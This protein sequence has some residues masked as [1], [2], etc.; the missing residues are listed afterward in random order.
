[1]TPQILKDKK[2]RL[3]S[4]V[5]RPWWP[6]AVPFPSRPVPALFRLHPMMKSTPGAHPSSIMVVITLARPY[7]GLGTELSASSNI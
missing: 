2:H 3:G 6:H 1:M 7:N 5:T 4:K